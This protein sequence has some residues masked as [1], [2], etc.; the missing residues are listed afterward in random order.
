MTII[1]AI[2]IMDGAC[3]RLTQGNFDQQ[4]MYNTNP[5]IVAQQFEAAGIKR[6]HVVDLDG[7]KAGKCINLQVLQN[8]AKATHLII[9]FGGGIK[10]DEDVQKVFNAGASMVTVGS[11]AVTH[12]DSL[13]QWV[14]KY[15]ANNF[16]VGADVWQN[17][18]KINGWLQQTQINVHQFIESIIEI[19]I[20][21]I[22]CTDI[23]KDG[24]LQGPAIKLYEDIIFN[25]PAIQLIASGGV[26]NMADVAAVKAIGCK[27]VIIGKAL[28]EGNISIQQLNPFL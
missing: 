22:F 8:I 20:H 16:L 14:Q 18:I 27:G 21:N 28:Y 19:G 15:G 11:I 2:D 10:T 23:S 24:L 1:P 4:I 5:V 17:K 26:S 25:N 12:I 13:I 9:D 6:L 3:V 7:A